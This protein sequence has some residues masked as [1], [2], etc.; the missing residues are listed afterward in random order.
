MF[1]VGA[2]VVRAVMPDAVHALELFAETCVNHGQ[3]CIH[4]LEMPHACD[5]A[6]DFAMGWVPEY[7]SVCDCH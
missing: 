4:R 6:C 1:L 5:L 7:T 3:S 2:S